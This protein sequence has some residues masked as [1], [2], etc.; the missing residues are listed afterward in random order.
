[1][2]LE[3]L[4]LLSHCMPRAIDNAKTA[5]NPLREW[6]PPTKRKTAPQP[7][8]RQT[9]RGGSAILLSLLYW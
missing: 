9:S 3:W 4:P 6:M 2:P 8:I 1:M 7:T 5:P